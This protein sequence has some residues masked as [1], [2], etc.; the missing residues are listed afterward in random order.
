MSEIARQKNIEN[1][2]ERSS[3]PDVSMKLEH[4][5]HYLELADEQH[6]QLHKYVCGTDDVD[7]SNRIGWLLDDLLNI[8]AQ[9]HDT[10]YPDGRIAITTQQGA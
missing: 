6:N 3:I 4:M 7:I 8:L 10:L 2:P 5:R 9:V 1:H